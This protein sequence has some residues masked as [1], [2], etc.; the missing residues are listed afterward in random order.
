MDQDIRWWQR[1]DN[2]RKSLALLETGLTENE[3]LVIRNAIEKLQILRRLFFLED[4]QR[5]FKK[6][7][8]ILSCLLVDRISAGK[9]LQ[10]CLTT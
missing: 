4:G 6:A 2:F 9:I 8:A 1:F 7:A 5:D 10:N 3:F